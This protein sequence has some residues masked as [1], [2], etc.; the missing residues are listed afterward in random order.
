MV[1]KYK[2]REKEYQK[3]YQKE[4]YKKNK[5]K[6]KECCENNKD[7]RK[8]QRKEYYKNNKEKLKGKSK[9][10]RENH[11]NKLKEKRKEY[12]EK[13]KDKIKEYFKNN[14]GKISKRMKRYYQNNKDKRIEYR[15]QL[16]KKENKRRKKL[17]LLLVGE[18]W[19]SESELLQIVTTLFSNYEIIFHCRNWSSIKLE[20]DIYIPEL[21]LAFEYNGIQ[22]YKYN[23]FFHHTKKEFEEQQYRDRIKKKL[24]KQKG[25]TLIKIKYTEKLSEQLVLSKLKYFNFLII[26]KQIY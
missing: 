22:H 4:Y 20:L 19:T 17:G 6:P 11:K 18:G 5:E 1:Y 8:D 3:E 2:G 9:E 23:S 10:Y 21:K 13:N 14:K 25:I 16:V 7:K 26:Q 12:C 15:L 24:C